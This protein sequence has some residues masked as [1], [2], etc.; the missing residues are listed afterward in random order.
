[1][2]LRRD[3]IRL[4]THHICHSNDLHLI[5]NMMTLL[6]TGAG[7]E[8]AMG[9]RS[10]LWMAVAVGLLHPA[11]MLALAYF[12]RRRPDL[13]PAVLCRDRVV[14]FSGML[15]AMMAVEQWTGVAGPSSWVGI[16]GYVRLWFGARPAFLPPISEFNL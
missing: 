3:Y 9:S 12:G 16:A 8:R 15:F 5:Y 14:G 2:V 11:L 4:L 13:V 7:L 10:F 6:Q 1:M